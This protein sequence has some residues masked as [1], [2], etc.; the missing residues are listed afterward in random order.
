MGIRKIKR[1]KRVEGVSSHTRDTHTQGHYIAGL[2]HTRVHT[3][4]SDPGD[5]L[6]IVYLVHSSD[7]LNIRTNFSGS[8]RGTDVSNCAER[9]GGCGAT[10]K[11]ALPSV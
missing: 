5:G 6:L 9:S 2:V 4:W 7:R 11:G 1:R 10:R 3:R 8:K